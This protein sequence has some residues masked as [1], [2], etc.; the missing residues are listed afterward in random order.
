MT[1]EQLMKIIDYRNLKHEK[2]TLSDAEAKSYYGEDLYNL[3]KKIYEFCRVSE[4][5][6][7]QHATDIEA[8][9]NIMKKGYIVSTE[10]LQELPSDISLE[11]ASDVEYDGDVK[12]YIIDG[13]KCEMR[14]N[15]IRDELSDTQHF[16]ENEYCNLDFGSITNP[17]VN[18][19]GFGATCLFIIPKSIQGS[20]E[21]LQY[22]ITESHFDEWEDSEVPETYFFRQ[23][24]PKQFLIGY[25]DVKNKRFVFN[26]EFQFGYGLTDEFELGLSSI[27]QSDLGTIIHNNIRKTK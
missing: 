24:I 12:T 21:Y 23:V 5:T 17:G 9:N 1:Y 14:L 10:E 3:I 6:I 11:K 7:Y 22:G 16:F 19:S 8:A 26:S 2:I 27:L 25:L 13:E 15:G 4:Y 18:R 20:R